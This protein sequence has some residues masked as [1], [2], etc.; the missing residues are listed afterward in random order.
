MKQSAL[1]VELF[2]SHF[3]DM[4]TLQERRKIVKYS[5]AHAIQLYQHI[6]L[7]AL[8]LMKQYLQERTSLFVGA[9]R[10]ENIA[11]EERSKTAK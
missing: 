1:K 5:S 2:F 6:L 4:C 3:I 9:L 11:G 10:W 7:Q 8:P